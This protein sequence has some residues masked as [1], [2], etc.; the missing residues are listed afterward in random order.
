INIT[1]ADECGLDISNAELNI[2]LNNTDVGAADYCTDVINLG[3]GNYSCE[4]ETTVT[5]VGR[6]DV[7]VKAYNVTYHNNGTITLV[8]SFRVIPPINNAPNL[9]NNTMLYDI[10]GWGATFNFS[11]EVYDKDY[12]TVN[13][14]FWISSDNSTWVFEDSKNCTAC[15]EWNQLN[16]S[17]DGFSCSDQQEWYYKFNATDYE[18]DTELSGVNFT[19]EKDDVTVVYSVG[20]GNATYVNR[21]SPGTTQLIFSVF[22]ADN[23][24]N[25][26]LSAGSNG[27]FWVS[28]NDTTYDTGYFNQTNSTG[29]LNYIFKPSCS[30][31]YA[32]GPQNWTGGIKGDTCYFDTNDTESLIVYVVGEMNETLVTPL[33]GDFFENDNVS[34]RVNLTQECDVADIVVDAAVDFSVHHD[35]YSATC[36]VVNEADGNYN[37]TWNVTGAPG[38][39]YN[40]TVNS[41]RQYLN[42]ISKLK[43]NSFFHQINPVI[44]DA[45]ADKSSVVWGND[46]AKSQVTFTVNVTDDDDTVDVYLWE[47]LG[48]ATGPWT[49]ADQTTCVDCINTT[50]TFTRTYSACGEIG[51]WYWKINASDTD[52]L[53]DEEPVYNFNVTKRAVY[54]VHDS[55]NNTDVVRTGTNTTTLKVRAFDNY[56]DANLGSG[57]QG[58]FWVTTNGT[59]TEIWGNQLSDTTDFQGYVEYD[60]EPGCSSPL[61]L[62]GTQDW[63]AGIMGGSCYLDTNSTFFELDINGSLSNSLD[64]PV[65]TERYEK[66]TDMTFFGTL[67]DDCTATTGTYVSSADT[68]KFDVTGVNTY[69]CSAFTD[70]GNGTYSCDWNN[71]GPFLG[72]HNVTLNSTKAYY[73]ASSVLVEEAFR[74]GI[75]PE[76]GET[77][78]DVLSDGWGYNY[79]FKVEFR[80]MEPDDTDNITFYK[81]YSD[82]GPWYTVA[83]EERFNGVSWSNITFNKIFDCSDLIS[84]PYLYYK[85]NVTDSFGFT[86]ESVIKNITL[87]KD[88]IDVIYISGEY[89][90]IDRE[91]SDSAY[92]KVLINDTD[93]GTVVAGD[94]NATVWKTFDAASY[95]SGN[96]TVTD[97][98]GY[99]NYSFDPD[100]G[101]ST[102]D[103]QYWLIGTTGNT[104]YANKNMTV[105]KQFAIVGQLKNNLYRPLQSSV[106]NV[107]DGVF[108]NVSTTTD[109]P[110]EGAQTGAS[111]ILNLTH[112]GSTTYE[113]SPVN[114]E[115]T[116]VYNCTW[117]STA[118]LE[119]NY[120]VNMTSTLVNYN[121]NN[122]WWTERFWLENKNTTYDNESVT[123]LSGG[124]SRNF[125]FNLSV[126][127]IEAD[128][129]TCTLFTNTTGTWVERGQ[130]IV[131]GGV[132]NCSILVWDFT[133]T[134]VGSASYKFMVEDAE[135]S[136]TF[137]TTVFT[138]LTITK[139]VVSVTFESLNDTAVNRSDGSDTLVVRVYDTENKSYVN[140]SNV[141]FWVTT[142]GLNI[143]AGSVFT[144]NVTGHASFAFTPTCTPYYEAGH[145]LWL[146]GVTDDNYVNSNTTLN[147]T[148]T[149]YGQMTNLVSSPAGEK[150]LRGEENVTIR[151]NITS[152]C[153]SLETMN[154]TSVNF[155]I[156]S[157]HT[158]TSYGCT[159]EIYNETTG[160]YNCTFDTGGK[161]PRGYNITMNSTQEF[162]LIDISTD[163]YSAGVESFWIETRPTLVAPNITPV[164]GGWGERHY[165][166]VNSTDYDLDT[167]IVK[168][169]FRKDGDSYAP[170]NSLTN[171][172]ISGVD[173]YVTFSPKIFGTSDADT[174]W[175]YKFNVTASDGDGYTNETIE[176]SFYVEPDTTYLEYITGNN[177]IVNRSALPTDPDYNVTFMFRAWDVD[178]DPD[179]IIIGKKIKFYVTDDTVS[180]YRPYPALPTSYLY[181]NATGYQKYVF[182]PDCSYDVGPQKWKAGILDNPEFNSTNS[183][184]FYFNITTVPLAAMLDY[185]IGAITFE[186]GVDN[187]LLRGNVSDDCGLVSGANVNISVMQGGTTYAECY[188]A[189]DEMSGWYNCTIANTIHNTWPV[190]LYNVTIKADKA[191]YNDSDIFV[192]E[193]AFRLVT[194][195]VLSNPTATSTQG[196]TLGGWGELWTFTVDI[197][198]PDFD[199]SN[200]SFWINRTGSW[201]FMDSVIWA[202]GNPTITFADKT[203]SC[204]GAVDLGVKQYKFNV[205]DDYDYTDE[206]S[207]AMT[208]E[209][210]DTDAIP[211][212]TGGQSVDRN[213]T[214]TILLQTQL[215]DTDKGYSAVGPGV[216]GKVWITVNGSDVG[217]FDDGY[218]LQTDA[219]G[220]LNYNFDINC[221]Y[222]TGEHAW[223]G[224]TSGSA[225]YKD[226]AYP[227]EY[228]D[229]LGKLYT[230]VESPVNGS[231][232]GTG[233]P[234]FFRVNVTSDC[235]DEGLI[236]SELKGI[237]LQSPSSSWTS[238]SPINSEGGAD[239]GWYNCTWDSTFKEPGNWTIRTNASNDTYY[240][241]VNTWVDHFELLNNPPS[242]SDMDGTPDTGAWGTVYTFSVNFT[243]SDADDVDCDLYVTTDNGATWVLRNSTTLASPAVC[244]LTVSDFDCGDIGTDNYFKFGLDDGYNPINTTNVSGPNITVNNIEMIYV[245]G[246]DQDVDRSYGTLPLKVYVNDTIKGGSVSPAVAVYF[247]ITID[248]S[249][250][251]LDGSNTTSNGNATYEFTP[252]CSYYP[253]EQMWYA[254]VN[255]SC[256]TPKNTTEYNLTVYGTLTNTLDVP[257]GVEYF[258]N[259]N[260]T[261]RANVTS[262]CAAEV[263]NETDVTFRYFRTGYSSTCPVNNESTGY[264]N[265]TFNNT[266]MP[267]GYYDFEMNSSQSFYNTDSR[268][269]SYVYGISSFW[270]ETL[271]ILTAPTVSPG[272][273]GWGETFYFVT[274]ATDRDLDTMTVRLWLRKMPGGSWIMKNSTTAQGINQTVNLSTKFPSGGDMGD[275]EFNF[276]VTA[277]DSWDVYGTQNVSFTVEANDVRIEILSGNDS[278]V[279]RSSL[280]GN[281]NPDVTF[282]VRIFD[283]DRDVLILDPV[284]TRFYVTKDGS[285]FETLA[286]VSNDTS[287]FYVTL[288]PDCTYGIGPQMWKVSSVFSGNSWYKLTNTTD[289]N[290]NITTI[291]LSANIAEPNG[292]TRVRGVDDIFIRVNVTDECG[293]VAGA[294]SVV[295]VER[296]AIPYFTCPPDATMS[297]EANGY[298]NCTVPSAS[299]TIWTTGEYDVKI[300]SS[301]AYYNSSVTYLKN[302]AFRLVTVSKLDNPVITSVSSIGSS[303]YGWGEDWTFEVDVLDE[304]NDNVN[305]YLWVNLTGSWELLNSTVCTNCGGSTHTISFTGHDFLCTDIGTPDFKF[306]VS[307]DYSYTNETAGTFNII[308]DDTITYY[309]LIGDSSQIDREGNDAET[310]SIKIR[311]ADVGAYVGTT[312]PNSTGK[313][314]VTTDGATYD[315]G[316]SNTT[317]ALGYLYYTFDPDC[318]Y[319]VG[320]QKWYGGPRDDA[321]YKDSNSPVFDT[322]LVGQLK[323]SIINPV[324]SSSVFVGS[325]VNLNASIFDECLVPVSGVSI[326]HEAVS[327]FNIFEDIVPVVN[328]SVGHYNSTWDTMF[329]QGGNWSFRINASKINHYGNSTIFS[330]WTY[331]NNTVPV[332]ENFTVSPEVEGWGRVYTY[333]VQIYDTQFDNITCDLYVS[334]DNG[335]LWVLKNSTFIETVPT[336]GYANCTLSASDFDCSEIGTDNMYKFQIFDG[337][338]KFNTSSI[339][340]PN[341]TVDTVSIEYIYG[342][343]SIVNRSGAQT[344]L[345]STRVLDVDKGS[346]PVMDSSSVTFW[347]TY[348]NAVYNTGSSVSTNSTGYADYIFNPACTPIKYEVGPQYWVAGVT[349]SCY[350]DINTSSN[351]TTTIYGSMDNQILSPLGT[352]F[353]EGIDNVTIRSNVTSDCSLEETMNETLVNFTMTSQYLGTQYGCTTEVYNETTGYYNC[354]FE[355]SGKDPREYNITMNSTQ[356][357]YITNVTTSSYSSGT[358][359]FRIENIPVMTAPTVSPGVGGWGEIFY[360]ATNVTDA[361]DD[362]MTVRLWLR[363]KPSGSWILKNSTTVQG[364]D[365]VVNLSTKFISGNDIGDWEFNY[366]VTADD[367]WDVY[368]TQNVSFTVEPNDVR[369]ELISGDNSIVNRSSLP[370]NSNPDVTFVVSVFDDDR[371]ILIADP[372]NTRFYVTKDG[373]NFTTLATVSNDS[374]YFYATLDPDCTYDVGPQ[375]WK[376]SSVFSGNSWYKMTNSSDFSF[377]ITTVPLSANM[378]QPDGITRVRGVDDIFIRGNVT[379]ECGL[380]DGASSV[381]TVEK[382]EIP[383]FTCPPDAT[384]FD[385]DN[386]YYNCTVPSASTSGWSPGDFDVKIET[387]KAYYNSSE[388]VTSANAF[389]LVT[390]P[391]VDNPVITTTSTMGI[392]DFGWG[393]DWKFE[394]DIFDDDNDDVNV[395]LWVNLTGDWELLNSTVCTNCGGTT[396]T[397]SFSGHDFVCSDIGTRDFKFNVS[398]DYSY[399]NE[400]SG[401]FNIIKDD[402][403]TYYG[404]VGDGS[405]I[406]REG[407]DDELFAVRVRDADVNA[408]AGS[409]IP[410]ATGKI[411]VTTDGSTYDAGT[412]NTTDPSGYLYYTF[413]PDCSYG[414]GAQT[415]YGGP[416]GDSCY[417]DSNSPVFD[418]DFIGQ[419][420]SGI[421]NPVYGSNIFVG[422]IVNFNTSIFDECIVPVSDVTI[423]HEAA[424]PFNLFEDI[425]PAVNNS[426]GHYNSTWDT[427]FHQGGN[428]SFRINASK[429]DYYSNSTIFSNWTYLNNTPPTVENFTVSPDVEGWGRIYAYEAQISDTQFDNIT[430]DLYVSTDNGGS[431][432]LKNSTFIETVL[433][434]GNAN[435]TLSSSDFDCSEIGTDNMYKFQIYDGTNKFNTS[436]KSGPN[437]TTDTVSIEYLYGNDSVVNRSGNQITLF[438]AR[439]LDVDKGSIPVMNDSSVTFWT[440]HNNVVYNTGIVISTNSTGYADY[441]FNP[442]C[443]PVNYGVGPQYW[444]AGVTDSCYAQTNFTQENYT[445]TIVGDLINTIENPAYGTEYLRGENVTLSSVTSPTI[446][447]DCLLGLENINND[448]TFY[449]EY[450]VANYSCSSEEVA[451][452]YYTCTRN[453]TDMVARFYDTEMIS[454]EPYYNNGTILLQDHI[455][456]KTV[457]NMTDEVAI[458]SVGGWGETFYFSVNVTDE[459]LDNVTLNLYVKDTASGFWGAPK[460]STVLYSPQ[461]EYVTLSWSDAPYCTVGIWEYRFEA[462]DTHG[463]VSFTDSHN[464]TIEKDDVE[465]QY[466]FGDGSYVWRNGSD[467]T[468]LTL[469]IVDSD[470]NNLSVGTGTSARFWVTTDANDSGSWDIGKDTAT[471]DG[472]IDYYF[473]QQFP[474]GGQKCDYTVGIQKWKGGIFNDICYKD[475]NSTEYDLSV[476]SSLVPNVTN[477]YSQ[478]Y[479]RGDHIPLLTSVYDDCGPVSNVTL[480]YSLLNMPNQ[481][482]C[483][484]QNNVGWNESD[485]DYNCTWDSTNKPYKWYNVTASVSKEFFVPNMTS[486]NDRFFL[487]ITPQLES[488]SVYPEVGG[489]GENHQ[490]NVR[491]TSFDLAT[492]NVSLWK[493]FDNVSWDLVNWQTVIMPIGQ[494]VQF[495]ERFTCNDY[496]TPPSGVN[497]YKIISENVFGFSSE[498]LVYN[499]TLEYDNITL[500]ITPA[501]NDTVRRLGADDAFLEAR[502]YDTDYGVYQNNTDANIW[503]TKDGA[504][505]SYNESCSSDDGYCGIIYNPQCDSGVGLQN[506]KIEVYDSCYQ[507]I[508][509]TDV[510]LSVIGQLYSN[511]IN[512]SLDDILNKN[513]TT[514]FNTTV[515]DD[516]DNNIL[517]ASVSWYNSTP[518]LLG[519]GYNVS[520]NIPL[521][522]TKG[523]ETI[524]TNSTR[525]YYDYGFNTTDV[526]VYG[527]SEISKIL[528]LNLSS[529]LAGYD[530]PVQCIVIDANTTENLT[531]YNVSFYKN[532]VFQS[533]NLTDLNGTALW[534][535]VTDSEPYG[536][537]NISCKISND[538]TLYYTPAVSYANTTVR[539]NR[540]LMIQS[541]VLSNPDIYRNDSFTPYDTNITVNIYDA[542]F[543][544]A[545]N[546]DVWFYNSTGFMDNCTTDAFGNCHI[547]YNAPDNITPQGYAVYVNATKA[548]L[549]NSTTDNTTIGVYGLLYIN[550]TGPADDSSWSKAIT[551]NLSSYIENENGYIDTATVDWYIDSGFVA[552]G[553][554]TT[555]PLVS[556][557]PGPKTLQSNATRPYYVTGTD[558]ISLNINGLVD[559]MWWFPLN[560]SKQAYPGSFDVQC[561]VKDNTSGL[562][563]EGYAVDFW[564]LN[565][566]S[567]VY[568]GTYATN[569]LGLAGFTWYPESKGVLDFKCNI[570]DNATVFYSPNIGEA[571]ATIIIEDINPPAI[572]NISIIPNKTIEANL[573]YTN[574]TAVVTDDILV[575][576]VIAS[577][578]LPNGTVVNETMNNIFNDTYRVEY[579]SPIGGN[580]SVDIVA[581]DSP[582]EN[583]T[584]AVYAGNISV[585]GKADMV[586]ERTDEYVAFGITQV[587]GESFMLTVNATNNGPANAYDV[588]ITVT[589][590]PIGT[591]TYNTTNYDCGNLSVGEMCSR[592]FLVTVPPKTAPQLITVYSTIWWDNPDKTPNSTVGITLIDVA[593]NPVIDILEAFIQNQTV[594]GET[595]TIGTLT[596]S[597]AGNDYV[598]NIVLDKV[599]DTLALSCPLCNLTISKSTEETLPAGDYFI[600][601]ISIDIPYGQSAG[602]YWTYVSAK[603]DNAPQDLVIVNATVPLDVTWERVPTTFGTILALVN[604]DTTLIGTI[605]A[606]NNGNS[607]RNMIVQSGGNGSLF[608]TKSP[609]SF[610]MGIGVSANV[611]INYSIPALTTQGMYYVQVHIRDSTADP[612]DGITDFWLNVTDLPPVI[613]NLSIVPL[614]YEPDVGHS[615]ITA[616]V[617]DNVLVSQ[618]W[619][620]STK[621]NGSEFIDYFTLNGSDAYL[622]YS[623]NEIGVHKVK[624]CANDTANLIS[625]TQA[626]NI[627]VMV[628]TTVVTETNITNVTIYGVLFDSGL[629]VT[630]NFTTFNAGYSRALEVN[631][632]AAYPALWNVSP[633]QWSMGDIINTPYTGEAVLSIPKDVIG[634]YYIN[635]TSNWTNYDGTNDTL[636]TPIKIVIGSNPELNVTDGPALL[637]IESGKSASQNLTLESIGNDNASDIQ[638]NCTGGIACADFNASFDPATIMTLNKSD[639]ANFTINISVPIGYSTGVYDGIFNVYTAKTNTSVNITVVIPANL[640]WAHNPIIISKDVVANTTGNFGSVRVSNIG[641]LPL[642]VSASVTN[643]TLFA[644][645][646]SWVDLPVGNHSDAMI[647]YT[648][649]ELFSLNTY[650]AYFRTTNMTA[651]PSTRETLLNIT[652]HPLYLDILSPTSISP[653]LN[654]SEGKNLTAAFNLTYASVPLSDNVTWQINL[655]NDG[656][657]HLVN[658][659]DINYSVVSNLW[660]I[661]FTAPDILAGV[662]Y[663]LVANVFD[664]LNN[665]NVIAA[666]KDAVIY[667]DTIPPELSVDMVSSIINGSAVPIY[668]NTTDVGGM[669]YLLI[670]ITMPNGT[671]VSYNATLISSVGND[672]FYNL[673]FTETA[674]L[675]PYPAV[676]SA[677]DL[678]GNVN[679]TNAT[680]DSYLPTYFS[681]YAYDLESVDNETAVP[682]E[683]NMYKNNV[684]ELMHNIN[685][686]NVTGL[687][688]ESV[689]V[690]LYDV[691]VDVLNVTLNFN[692]F[693]MPP[694]GIF[695]PV[696]F[697]DIPVSL[698]GAGPKKAIYLDNA[699]DTN[700]NIIFDY[701]PYDDVA[702]SDLAVYQ[703]DNWTIKTGCVNQWIRKNASVDTF[704]RTVSFNA[705]SVT[706]AYA[707][708]QYLCGNNVCEADYGESNSICPTDCV[709]DV[710]SFPP[711]PAVPT[712]GGGGGAGDGASSGE[713]VGA[714]DGGAGGEGDL[715]PETVDEEVVPIEI[716]S[717]LLYIT[718][719]PGEKS[720]HSIEIKNN[721]DKRVTSQLSVDGLIWDLIQLEKTEITVD[722]KSTENVKISAYAL[723]STMPGIYTG[724]IVVKTGT[725]IYRTPVTVKVEVKKEALL[726]VIIE[727]LSDIVKPGDEV[728]IMVTVKNMGET[729]TVEDIIL[730]YVIKNLYDDTVLTTYTETLAVNQSLSY[731]KSLEIPNI[732]KEDRY[733]I[734]VN[735]KYANGDKFATSAAVI[736]VSTKPW[737]IV[738]LLR[739]SKSWVTYV[740]LLIVLPGLY[741]GRKAYMSYLDKKKKAARYIFPMDYSKLPQKGEESVKVGKIAETDVN[742]YINIKNLTMHS[743]AAGGTG[744]GKSVTAMSTAEELLDLGLPVVVFDPT[745]QW[746]GFIRPCK[747]QHML[748]LYP[749]YGLKPEHAKSYKTNII[750]VES[751]DSL[752]DEEIDIRQYMKPGEIT[753]FVMSKLSSSELDKFVRRTIKSI[754]AIQWPEAKTLK[755]LIVYDEMHRLLPKYGGK[756]GYLELER[757]CREFRKWGLGLFMISQVLADFKGAIKANVANEIQ[758]RTKYNGDIQRIKQR[759]GPDYATRVARLTVGAGLIQNPEYNEG[760]PWFIQFRPLRHDTGRLSNEELDVYMGLKKSI[761]EIASKIAKF[762]S[763]GVDT[764][765]IEIELNMARTKLQQGVFKMSETYIQ[766]L[767]ARLESM[768]S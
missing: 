269:F 218:A 4:W 477:V 407:N 544:P 208:L 675:G 263:M 576:S 493:S 229:S 231:S 652:I 192:V 463:D 88:D 411:F 696:V 692:D 189:G 338:N 543:G 718:L 194:R 427:M 148:T 626:Y 574:I 621:P 176:Q 140:N 662:G 530:V 121:L 511:V 156:T 386:G 293:L 217:S 553:Q 432:I 227:T 209:K 214:V 255:D 495:N 516:C 167:L 361:D 689:Y 329:H 160:Y 291:P 316:T 404:S 110:A 443:S 529:Y 352:K 190:G 498:T 486:G 473:M 234:V 641:N 225:C 297:D 724:D 631:T 577:I 52:T 133:P 669:D 603:S 764:Y 556:Q 273:G 377:N 430:C 429:T 470:R 532:D 715:T 478:G 257:T 630:F 440:T 508:N 492:N 33:G 325:I 149:I 358:S 677:Y 610:T 300:D 466:S 765:D 664:V 608:V 356:M 369:I 551:L 292:I 638:F 455:F 144:T 134:D 474:E 458:T 400:T 600:S 207:S 468:T 501:T 766:S 595:T 722:K 222:T 117:D 301:K 484:K 496:L 582:P 298:Y 561:L 426:I 260:I 419:L 697:G 152:D 203:F 84:G 150:Y 507:N 469:D 268:V 183:S 682:L 768:S 676:I 101:Y 687:Y 245:D 93:F 250:Y 313:I 32:I 187:I 347:T 123:P 758:L 666:E 384:V 397:I 502:I 728:K 730:E 714:G 321:C 221:S 143:D 259:N 294:S 513:T 645:N 326:T 449:N 526:L 385:E 550:I 459:D 720:I 759:Y 85:F 344:T 178:K 741:F 45:S 441:Q 70:F 17:Y 169:W 747:D 504:T 497:Y 342:N 83:S 465:V 215:M 462:S 248:G 295:V 410:A 330:N 351:Y 131:T 286:T 122:T 632:T 162:Y 598:D 654:V 711:M 237:E 252:S 510:T 36:S 92:F 11:V 392:S 14:S 354:T 461:G 653:V 505:F 538:D 619:L 587:S 482:V 177:T 490:F 334:T 94:I 200:V 685:S 5:G 604:T 18:N 99:V 97:A 500:V 704:S 63:K 306:N 394:V 391:E 663:D 729:E 637:V 425:A 378:V 86:D 726:D 54:F 82:A 453:T 517:D 540:T 614:G 555:Y 141:T 605:T 488:L 688:N 569:E 72:L 112:S 201:E 247:N 366:T 73:D 740:I 709:I 315:A 320:A 674:L 34:I 594:H 596:V 509:S 179:A 353:I 565:D 91:G 125:T 648:A 401:A 563:V 450:G 46:P 170:A 360:F 202:Q 433:T 158:G 422:N 116:G 437:L 102:S 80:D 323:S 204:S 103:A 390:V 382:S 58:Y 749:K 581:S 197:Q 545:D 629:N 10:D 274:N 372:A 19:V 691:S 44:F 288:D 146:A 485:G 339:S 412:S 65:P 191:Y 745:A 650:T 580:Y 542:L 760:K 467:S 1:L 196:G 670:E 277:D 157:Q 280:P 341:L 599:G 362:I 514:S 515:F 464:F 753:V 267:P 491:L 539:V 703:C 535:W 489:W 537:Y 317:N 415:W 155:T 304:D 732:T 396:H 393:E 534:M 439:V 480:S 244:N 695:N 129:V 597:S 475:K 81:A 238:C 671:V 694:G 438:S 24:S 640:T 126:L 479:L 754:F 151:A 431:W 457:P 233:T 182:E 734:N 198:D 205:S 349:D 434:G 573:N 624:I 379:D 738:I 751:A 270:L 368:G 314:F 137:N 588:S 625:C 111:V 374:G 763:K 559:V 564:Y 487:G 29:N 283:D 128:D 232:Y 602:D 571:F 130:S 343:D 66:E 627:S 618:V 736:D 402:T 104:C 541:I 16:F 436:S 296:S 406:D 68:V 241:A 660:T 557:M 228:F 518:I 725:M 727:T 733:V 20:G 644:V 145:Q 657:S 723:P 42:S 533:S 547:G 531:D 447:D 164:S 172:T 346:I 224:G 566:S 331:L 50:K 27:S 546:A 272:V 256:Y 139:P 672:Y 47:S 138:G 186:K 521:N 41:T 350:S 705:T 523:P 752:T 153:S 135:I 548:G 220:Y 322:S 701:S 336:S 265:C 739:L 683:F 100:C 716:K 180:N 380:V 340:G 615:N 142:D 633:S 284:N 589:E 536:W 124:W 363:K 658:I 527:F 51:T 311:D 35:T 649:P 48:S 266:G 680:F 74:I 2:T 476:N 210:D 163:V 290:F 575:Y 562:S 105:P 55:G 586:G 261:L 26:V 616:Q 375:M 365:V 554:N 154:E 454:W 332:A 413:N 525:Q 275:W 623:E 188:P 405:Q 403:I 746:S 423:T 302:N 235:V 572:T 324:Y 707:L 583:N 628:N 698:I 108:F 359:S 743:I 12:D 223:M 282:S 174:T 762:K 757:G 708:A 376:A 159:T 442:T 278:I 37:C 601:E 383:Y 107:T 678:S 345:F 264:Y 77:Y 175:Y 395:Y 281:S 25:P 448:I 367:S 89:V 136:N 506:W 636:M 6:Y 646:S 251:V 717:T 328:N 451:G 731:I 742:A 307:D 75:A 713:G 28:Y 61:Y 43:I 305:V 38:G 337:T 59:A 435:C 578:T 15:N 519:T 98:N 127:D 418:T 721:Q 355:T 673:D 53:S 242:Y 681:G 213:G 642:G 444:K 593:S 185:P 712:S 23:V 22:D 612:A 699:M 236:D 622:N 651:L 613:S 607:E 667:V 591:V 67:S 254:E 239:L 171:N 499:Y 309:G 755:V 710:P 289:Q 166:T 549:E 212:G 3:S 472:E 387:S 460:N 702:V 560:G 558:N 684:F 370:G 76:M 522:Y 524:I 120:T 570:T 30:P 635:F 303:D 481:Y 230:D 452:G 756:G 611:T 13:V 21:T 399:I 78:V 584:N 420:K 240:T 119:G 115:G 271:P 64:V 357:Y 348:D 49:L 318:S 567:Y 249:T 421:I 60:F 310:F 428:W 9:T 147:Y 609:G 195:P 668:V 69:L 634:V 693:S 445:T 643:T 552:T 373:I 71:I 113:C 333:G 388:T 659:T 381:F 279:N 371:D 620:N 389:R 285:N 56:T 414:V 483:D 62:T 512:P 679:T 737:P 79:T 7:I 39:W 408:Y 744:S 398:D 299:T 181:T 700:P 193:N 87:E 246:N 258:L 761:D 655:T 308:K 592:D 262:D 132:G 690:R 106:F 656:L 95:D 243:D 767:K 585:W 590:D 364:S 161:E 719:A 735:A 276:T 8:D 287:E 253:G 165:F 494:W 211:T 606:K 639:S 750:V 109:C 312:I 647:N 520:W 206:I 579:L 40:I 319:E 686:D 503:V 114:D 706:G 31:K 528:P 416:A 96:A 219:S 226:S 456:V 617:T 424:S 748:D 184:D 417:K 665:I 199:S 446:T 327:P 335:A 661:N 90:S 57:M 173:Q 409:T 568:N 118:K 471:L 168:A 216:D